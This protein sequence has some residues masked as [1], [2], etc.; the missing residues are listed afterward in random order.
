MTST[1]TRSTTGMSIQQKLP[2]LVSGFLLLVIVLYSWASYAT[3]K[4]A[5]VDV[6]RQRLISLTGQVAQ[7]YDQQ[8]KTEMKNTHTLMND[9]AVRH[10]VTSSGRLSKDAAM[11]VLTKGGLR[12]ELNFRTEILDASGAP[13]LDIPAGPLERH[14]ELAGEI[15]KATVGPDYAAIGRFRLMND[16]LV[17][18]V[19]VAVVDGTRPVGF[20]VRWRRIATAPKEAV[21]QLSAL[22][23]GN[24]QLYFGNDRGDVWTNAST[25]VP[26]PP[27]NAPKQAGQIREYTRPGGEPVFA[28]S[29]AFTSAPWQVLIEFS[30]QAVMAPASAFLRRALLTG[31]L[32][33]LI[34]TVLVWIASRSITRPLTNLT[35]AASALAAGDYST[36]VDSTRKDEL[37]ELSRAF[38]AMTRRV[39]ESQ[40]SLEHKVRERTEELRSR[41]E[42]LETYAHSIS[43]DLRAPL[44]AMH[45]FSQA[46]L[47]DC[48]PQLDDVGR[49]YAA[50][51]VAGARRMDALIQDLLAYSRVSRNDMDLAS[52]S[53]GDVVHD[54]LAQVEGDVAASGGAVKVAPDLPTVRGHRVALVQSVANLVA[55]GLKFVPP[56]RTPELRVRAEK[57]NGV[58]RLWVEDNGIGIDA[59]HHERV[60]GVFERLHQS[61]NYPGTGIG[62]A[63]VR[64]SVER[65]GGRV[66]VVSAVGEGSRFWIELTSDGG[67]A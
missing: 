39:E 19:V 24:A 17:A 54:A 6:A 43:H 55:N 65:M 67:V 58:T 45:G 25:A 28:A 15:A 57:E 31:V 36:V 51:V 7:I 42:E 61:E 23:G 56:G 10:F 20:V 47:E 53:L 62:L 49:D 35:A 52:V 13:M 9:S 44:R 64:K 21:A 34:G 48:G 40:E 33:L 11:K 29:H 2:L 38:N 5:S 32:V 12:P 50:R 18:P 37:G 3:V 14:E 22:L 26:A 59:A 63:I 46:L 30:K 60:F 16:T 41:N 1:P 4:A 8:F 27:A 66:G